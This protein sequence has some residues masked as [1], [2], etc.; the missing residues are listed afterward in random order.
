M[1][2]DFLEMKRKLSEGLQVAERKYQ[3]DYRIKERLQMAETERDQEETRL[4]SRQPVPQIINSDRHSVRNKTV[5][6]C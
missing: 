1:T 2:G 4:L 5:S 3:L 6:D